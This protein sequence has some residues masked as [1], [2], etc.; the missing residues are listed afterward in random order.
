MGARL[1]VRREKHITHTTDAIETLHSHHSSPSYE[2]QSIQRE[3]QF[4]ER[5]RLEIRVMDLARN[6]EVW[7]G[8]FVGIPRKT[9]APYA[10]QAVTTTLGSFPQASHED[11]R[12]LARSSLKE[13]GLEPGPD[14]RR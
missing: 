10:K 4:Y 9:F 6:R 3:V 1:R 8:E 14:A 12:S 5:G 2:V 13:S 7:R 11:T